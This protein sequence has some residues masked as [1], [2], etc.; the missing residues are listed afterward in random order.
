MDSL[1]GKYAIAPGPKDSRTVVHRLYGKVIS[2]CDG[3]VQLELANKEI[4]SRSKDNIAVYVKTPKN[5]SELSE[6]MEFTQSRK[7]LL[8]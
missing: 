4:V 2:E 6:G 1:I 8:N 3:V 5:W 7:T